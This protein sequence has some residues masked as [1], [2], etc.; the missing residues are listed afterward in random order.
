MF[1]E[2]LFF[3]L[4]FLY[5]CRACSDFLG[6]I[7]DVSNIYIFFPFVSLARSLTILLIFSKNQLFVSL[8]FSLYFCLFLISLV[9]VFIFI[10]FC[11][12]VVFRILAMC[13]GVDFIGII[14]FWG[15]L[16]FSNVL[17][18]TLSN[19]EGFSA[20]IYLSTFWTLS[21]FFSPSGTLLTWVFGF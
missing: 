8:I 5:V 21:S 20:I 14:L 15:L 7:S 11:L 2:L 19:L 16:S 17:V 3:F 13:L 10:S 12:F 1:V 4:V 6:F 18:Y 9:H